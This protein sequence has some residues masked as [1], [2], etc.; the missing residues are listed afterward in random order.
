M[1]LTSA[2]ESLH[3]H[4]QSQQGCTD[5]HLCQGSPQYLDT[6]PCTVRCAQALEEKSHSLHEQRMH[7]LALERECSRLR[8]ELERLRE[9]QPQIN[10][11][12]TM[13]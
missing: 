6:S 2:F 7:Q 8:L 11:V 5:Y 3:T 1:T 4:C 10:G 9:L 13:H 12:Y